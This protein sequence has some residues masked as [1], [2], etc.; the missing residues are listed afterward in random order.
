ML[1][2]DIFISWL[3]SLQECSRGAFQALQLIV[4]VMFGAVD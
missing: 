3:E 1:P 4:F 2:A